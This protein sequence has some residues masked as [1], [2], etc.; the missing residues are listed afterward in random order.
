LIPVYNEERT[1][2]AILERVLQAPYLD[3]EILVID[4]G[5]T[6]ATPHIL[7]RWES[8]PCIQLLRHAHNLGKGAAVRTG[9]AQARGEITIIQDADLEYDPAEYP[10]LI[11]L[12]RHGETEVVYGSR[13]LSPGSGLG[14]SPFRIAVAALNVLVRVLYGQRITD[15]ATCYKAFRTAL[16]RSLQLR[17]VRFEL[18]AEITAKLCRLGV[19]ILEVPISYQPRGHQ[20]GKK[21]GWRD[22]WPTFWT[23]LKWR[24]LPFAVKETR[25]TRRFTQVLS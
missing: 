21:I 19:P 25:K 1:L 6:D 5:S 3:K 8:Q 2:D 24:F 4:D 22:A 20:D 9:L 13:Y 7:R 12:I 16:L 23:L 10:R 18:C 14:W 15:E 11:E 17:A